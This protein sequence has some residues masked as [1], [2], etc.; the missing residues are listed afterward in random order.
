M[1]SSFIELVTADDGDKISAS[2]NEKPHSYI[3]PKEPLKFLDGILPMQWMLGFK[4][5]GGS[6]MSSSMHW[7]SKHHKTVEL[8][9]STTDHQP[10]LTKTHKIVAFFET[11]QLFFKSWYR[12]LLPPR[13]KLWFVS[14]LAT[15]PLRATRRSTGSAG[16]ASRPLM[17]IAMDRFFPFIVSILSSIVG[18]LYQHFKAFA[19]IILKLLPPLLSLSMHQPEGTWLITDQ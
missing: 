14:R 7:L 2:K 8:S 11:L 9:E 10:S 3:W 18:L 12:G 16:S 5:G 17:L 6:Y 19:F 13:Y 15:P 4:I 1:F